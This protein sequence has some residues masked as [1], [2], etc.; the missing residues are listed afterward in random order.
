MILR[1]SL[2]RQKHD[3]SDAHAIILISF[4]IQEVLHAR[5]YN[6]HESKQKRYVI[7]TRS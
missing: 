5:Y 7:Q 3:E 2:S 1:Y 6:I 4:N